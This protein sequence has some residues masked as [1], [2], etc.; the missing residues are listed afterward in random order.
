MNTLPPHLSQLPRTRFAC[1]A[2]AAIVDDESAHRRG[3]ALVMAVVGNARFRERGSR[4]TITISRTDTIVGPLLPLCGRACPEALF[5]LFDD[6][7]NH[8]HNRLATT[9]DIYRPQQTFY[10]L[11]LYCVSLCKEFRSQVGMTDE[12]MLLFSASVR[13]Q[14]SSTEKKIWVRESLKHGDIRGSTLHFYEKHEIKP[15]QF[16]RAYR[17]KPER[18][19]ELLD[20]VAPRLKKEDTNFRVT[21]PEGE[22]LAMTLR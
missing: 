16:Y 12:D 10:T 22:H 19:D 7:G 3:P 20:L 9:K 5:I 13:Q 8:N 17:L 4:E 18:F 14:R 21:I 6:L 1:S 15:E 2:K 11:I